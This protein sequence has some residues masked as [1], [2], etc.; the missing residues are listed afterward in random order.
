MLDHQVGIMLPQPCSP[1]WEGGRN[2]HVDIDQEW[3]GQQ[4]GE[5]AGYEEADAPG[6]GEKMLEQPWPTVCYQPWPSGCY[7]QR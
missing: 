6:D 5:Q 3:P 1:L 7:Q 2:N 4:A